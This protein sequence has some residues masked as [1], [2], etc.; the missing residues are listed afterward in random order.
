MPNQL[1][2]IKNVLYQAT[3]GRR[4]PAMARKMVLRIVGG[5][6]HRSGHAKW[7]EFNATELDQVMN[8]LDS[9]LWREAQLT[10]NR[11]QAEAERK[12]SQYPIHLGGGGCYPLI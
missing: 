8:D 4:L 7:A 5:P 2:T 1:S 12:L 10:A 6:G 11:I 9:S 3:V